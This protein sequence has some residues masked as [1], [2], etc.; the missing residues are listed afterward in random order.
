L[1]FVFV[2][3]GFEVGVCAYKAGALLL[4]PHL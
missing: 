4:E 3:R 1:F 2:E